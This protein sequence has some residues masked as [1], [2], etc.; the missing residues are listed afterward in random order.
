MHTDHQ[1]WQ[2]NTRARRVFPTLALV[3]LLTACTTPQT[4]KEHSQEEKQQQT[5]AA[6]PI[7]V[8]DSGIGGLSVLNE[9]LLLDSHNNQS[10]HKGSDGN[11]D[12]QQEQFTY[13][14]DRANMPYG[15]YAA[16][17]KTELLQEH[18]LKDV[19]FLL[20]T[21]YCP[22]PENP[23]E[24]HKKN[25]VKA[26]VIACNT[27]TAYGKAHV[28]KHLRQQGDTTPVFGVIDAGA[29]GALEC[30]AP[31]EEASLGVLATLGTVSSNGYAKAVKKT[32]SEMP[33]NK[34]PGPVSVYQQG[35][36]GLAESI[37][38]LTAYLDPDAQTPRGEYQGPTLTK[39]HA[40][41]AAYLLDTTGNALLCPDGGCAEGTQLNSTTNYVRFHLL[42]LLEQLRKNRETKPLKAIILGCTHYPYV[43]EEL[44]E[45]LNYLYNYQQQGKYP[46]R[47]YMAPRIH[48]IDPAVTLAKDL[49]RYLQD[50]KLMNQQ[51]HSKPSSFFIS[52]PHPDLPDSTTKQKGGFTHAYKYGR[53][54]GTGQ[55]FVLRVPMTPQLIP[56]DKQESISQ[57]MPATHQ[58]LKAFW[59]QT[60]VT[61]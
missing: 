51:Q 5:R 58:A 44:R 23:A 3:F 15:L 4:T 29:R 61:E 35:A 20:D 31:G 19:T 10:L 40:Q 7:G 49:H 13:L 41:L 43:R 57:K 18:V 25:K 33:E 17:G 14:A 26:I 32:R 59:E 42:A 30:L 45:T 16:E 48:L 2:P 52:V 12:L 53:T 11:P 56:Q 34:R 8:F 9:L 50:N 6:L 47:P 22:N 38:G 28:E 1:R 54:A 60:L 55:T 36:D 46:Y 24:R 37:E 39:T 27:A 21:T